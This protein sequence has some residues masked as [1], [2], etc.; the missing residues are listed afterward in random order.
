[1][2][3]KFAANVQ[4]PQNPEG[5]SGQPVLTLYESKER[6]G[7]NSGQENRPETGS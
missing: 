2:L 7:E 4:A 6:K 3:P 5:I 1:M